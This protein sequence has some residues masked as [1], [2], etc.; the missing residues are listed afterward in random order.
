MFKQSKQLLRLLLQSLQPWCLVIPRRSTWV[1]GQRWLFY[2]LNLGQWLRFDLSS[3]N[4]GLCFNHL[5]LDFEVSDGLQVLLITLPPTLLDQCHPLFQSL[6]LGLTFFFSPQQFFAV[7]FFQAFVLIN[8]LLCILLYLNLHIW[9][10]LLQSLDFWRL[11]LHNA[12]R[13]S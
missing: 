12:T 7:I 11:F 1:L 9:Q 4:I 10:A 2:L 13:M 8:P 6:N 3:F 5:Q